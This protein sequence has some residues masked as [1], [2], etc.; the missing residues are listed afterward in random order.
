MVDIARFRSGDPHYTRR[1]VADHE[2][3]IQ[4][5]CSSFAQDADHLEDLA[6][7]T[8][9][10]VCE[11]ID[12]FT[13]AGSFRSWLR[14]VATSVCLNEVRARKRR[15]RRI[16][17]YGQD[18]RH[19]ILRRVMDPLS[20]TEERELQRA[21]YRAL[22]QLSERER[23]ALTLRV[24]DGRSTAEAAEIMAIAPAT[25]RSHL[26]H[27]VGHLRRLLEISDDEMPQHR[28]AG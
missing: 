17:R 5:V 20:I 12:T 18:H 6:Q 24:L 11:R 14:S 27:A 15:R 25:V 2:P 8:W 26:R 1:V 9:M 3:I 22:P 21:I 23:A 28:P 4:L 10:T 16:E 13:G 7:E 19:D